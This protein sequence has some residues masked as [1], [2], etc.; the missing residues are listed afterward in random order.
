MEMTVLEY[1]ESQLSDTVYDSLRQEPFLKSE[2]RDKNY[3]SGK[4]DAFQLIKWFI[5]TQGG[6][7]EK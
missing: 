4:M 3:Y 2:D 1:I 6:K 5:E 7:N